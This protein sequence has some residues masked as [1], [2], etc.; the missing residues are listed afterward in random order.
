MMVPDHRAGTRLRCPRCGVELIVPGEAPSQAT[1]TEKKAIAAKADRTSQSSI[2]KSAS[3]SSKSLTTAHF[4]PVK[5]ESVASSPPRLADKENLAS[6]KEPI[7]ETASVVDAQAEGIVLA[8]PA[9][10]VPSQAAPKAWIPAPDQQV[11]AYYLGIF[12]AALAIFGVAPA[13]WEWFALWQSVE[14]KPIPPWVFA[15]LIAGV[16]QLA[17]AVY[18]AQVPDWSALWATTVAALVAA[19][20]WATLLGTTLLGKQESMLVVL[21]GYADKLER[22]RA[23]GWCF[24][25]LCL[26]S[27]LAYFLGLSAARWHRSYRLL[28]DLRAE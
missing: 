8:T 26:T 19:A 5:E 13:V 3:K 18:L 11:T 17:Y 21:F 6:V 2:K 4:A 28:R 24:I 22:N 16:L 14:E 7:R 23:T 20:A 15:L 9:P 25:M 1:S 12:M 10:A 27:V